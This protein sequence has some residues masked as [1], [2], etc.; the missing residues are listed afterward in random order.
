MNP[1]Q[2]DYRIIDGYNNYI[3]F[4]DGKIKNTKTKKWLKCSY[5]CYNGYM[6]IGLY[7]EN[8]KKKNYYIHRLV[9]LAF[10]PNENTESYKIIDHINRDKTDNNFNNLRW[11]NYSLNGYNRDKTILNTSGHKGISLSHNKKYWISQYNNIAGHQKN[12]YFSI[13]KHGNTEAKDMAINDRLQQ[14]NN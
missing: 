10:I 9:A 8:K 1:Q 11:A 3:I 13:V 7:D 2:R 14:E 6:Y 4:N 5:N 12:H